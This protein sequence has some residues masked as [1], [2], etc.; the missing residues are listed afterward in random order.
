[1]LREDLYAIA[2]PCPLAEVTISIYTLKSCTV[3]TKL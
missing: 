1:M 3:W 2:V